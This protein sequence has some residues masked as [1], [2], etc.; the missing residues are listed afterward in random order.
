MSGE[1]GDVRRSEVLN[2]TDSNQ[3]SR[4]KEEAMERRGFVKGAVASITGLTAS[5][6]LG[7]ADSDGLLTRVKKRKAIQPYKSISAVEEVFRGHE[8]LLTDIAAETSL[9]SGDVESLGIDSLGSPEGTSGSG[10]TY[11][12]KEVDGEYLPEVRFMR[13]VKEGKLTVAVIPDLDER[14]AVLNP[15]DS[16][17]PIKFEEMDT[18]AFCGGCPNNK[19][20]E[21][22][23]VCCGSSCP[24]CSCY[25]CQQC[26]CNCYK[27]GWNCAGWCV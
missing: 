5:A 13:E 19:E 26:S 1:K 9:S 16:E 3:F 7:A 4:I 21:C 20:C 11:A 18:E 10:V 24:S 8:D 25:Y 15:K 6:G 17:E 22:E 14:Y 12:T 2:D 23:M 27:C